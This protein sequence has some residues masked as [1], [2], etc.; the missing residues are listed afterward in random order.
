LSD[1][2]ERIATGF[3]AGAITG[4]RFRVNDAI[5]VEAGVPAYFLSFC[6]YELDGVEQGDTDKSGGAWGARIG[7]VASF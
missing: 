7:V 3:G 2:S 5:S 4:A 1:G 6:D